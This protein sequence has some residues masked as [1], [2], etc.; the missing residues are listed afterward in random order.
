MGH[1]YQVPNFQGS[2]NTLKKGTERM[3]GME[4]EV[5]A[6]KCCP[7]GVAQ[8]YPYSLTAA[9][10]NCLRPVQEQPS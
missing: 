7:L 4:K 1:V 8:H 2:G 3:Q 9:V 5:S 6:I 10:V